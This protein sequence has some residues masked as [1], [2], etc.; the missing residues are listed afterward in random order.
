MQVGTA[1][2]QPHHYLAWT[3]YL[4]LQERIEEAIQI[5]S[6]IDAEK[7]KNSNNNS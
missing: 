5:F 3:Y 7:L 2:L 1:G 6:S 4:L